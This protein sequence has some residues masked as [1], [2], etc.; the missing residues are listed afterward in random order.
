M[1]VG[2]VETFRDENIAYAQRL[3]QAGG[4][5]ELHVLSGGFHGFCVLAALPPL[6]P[7]PDS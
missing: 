3:W 6:P 7:P 2:S 4:A 5:A 1:E